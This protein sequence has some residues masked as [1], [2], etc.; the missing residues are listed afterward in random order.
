VVID[1]FDLVRTALP[2]RR[3]EPPLIVH[4]DAPVAGAMI[5][6]CVTSRQCADQ[7][8]VPSRTIPGDDILSLLGDLP[9]D[10]TAREGGNVPKISEFFGIAIYIYYMDHGPPHFHALYGAEEAVIGIADLSLIAGRL[11]PRAMGLVTEWATL[12]QEELQ[13]VWEQAASRQPLSRI[14]PLR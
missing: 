8:E 12:H 6:R 9:P 3:A 4:T 7:V 11:P 1:E 13:T 5:T 2:R 10:A 14:E